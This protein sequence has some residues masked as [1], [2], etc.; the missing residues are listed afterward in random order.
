[1]AAPTSATAPPTPA[2]APGPWPARLAWAALP[3]TVGPVLGAALDEHSLAVARTGSV[4]A[5]LAWAGGLLAVAIPRTVSLTALRTLVPLALVVAVWAAVASDG[6]ATA[7]V[8]VTWAALS[9]VALL[10]PAVAE[11]FVDGSSYGDERRMLL[12]TPTPLVLGPLPLTWVAAVAG[13]VAGP[14]LLAARA[15]VAGAVV[16][17]VG[18]PASRVA[19]RALHGLSRRWVVFV[20]AGLVL[21]DL[22]AM[23]EAV[24]FPRARVAALRVAPAD[25][26]G[27]VDLTLG[28]LGEAL[29]LDLREPL[30]V[31]PRRGRVALDLIDVERVRFAPARPGAVLAE[32]ARRRIGAVAPGR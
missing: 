6:G 12:R 25:D 20:P 24:L 2:R 4:L 23:G 14:L 29:Q 9:M 17:A 13:P 28:T 19:I 22:Q 32:A 3:L 18:L 31:S 30:Q 10:W 21:H 26:D 27:V 1:M 11:A 7:V 16:L 15:W 5:W 8:A